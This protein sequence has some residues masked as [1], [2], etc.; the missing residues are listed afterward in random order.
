M[1]VCIDFNDPTLHH[2]I[3][4]NQQ[5]LLQILLAQHCFG[6]DRYEIDKTEYFR[7]KEGEYN[8]EIDVP[9]KSFPGFEKIQHHCIDYSKGQPVFVRGTFFMVR[10]VIFILQA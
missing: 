1:V 10:L 4:N 7:C 2:N 5:S 3:K 9:Y 6:I 8:P